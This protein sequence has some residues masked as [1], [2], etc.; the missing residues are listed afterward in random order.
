MFF[1][2]L[3]GVVNIIKKLRQF[4][5]TAGG[6]LFLEIFK[7]SVP[8]APGSCRKLKTEALAEWKAHHIYL[9]LEIA[10]VSN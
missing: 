5:Y 6:C 10:Y 8:F 3:K 4:G 1:F 2:I 9:Q 7:N